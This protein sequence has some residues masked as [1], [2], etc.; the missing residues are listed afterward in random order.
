MLRKSEQETLVLCC[1]IEQKCT[2]HQ[3]HIARF[4]TFCTL[5]SNIFLSYYKNCF[6][7]T[8]WRLKYLN[9]LQ[10]LGKFVYALHKVNKTF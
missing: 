1:V 2:H 6:M 8:F 10:N 7:S 3:R 9:G 4:T 5:A